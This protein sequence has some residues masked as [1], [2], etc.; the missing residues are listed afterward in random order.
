MKH[1]RVVKPLFDAV[2]VVVDVVLHDCH[3]VVVGGVAVFALHQIALAS[4]E[5]L[6][7]LF[8]QLLVEAYW[9]Q[10]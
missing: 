4:A 7:S 2:A 10:H 9:C 6:E 1:H 5:A 8:Y 3:V